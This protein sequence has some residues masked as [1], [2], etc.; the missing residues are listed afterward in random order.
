MPLGLAS[1]S[2]IRQNI[3]KTLSIPY[4]TVET[5]FQEELEKTNSTYNAHEISLYRAKK[6]ASMVSSTQQRDRPVLGSDQTLEVDG[7][8]CYKTQNLL[9]LEKRLQFLQGKTHILHS[10]VCLYMNGECIGQASSQASLTMKPLSYDSIRAYLSL[11]DHRDVL[12]SVGGYC[13]EGLGCLLFSKVNGDYYTILG[14]PVLELTT[15][16]KRNDLVLF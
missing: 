4:V 14:L 9:D 12:S 3:L 10:S 2:V 15:L 1:R 11:V 16:F 6:K 7:Q 13:F 8:V 5:S